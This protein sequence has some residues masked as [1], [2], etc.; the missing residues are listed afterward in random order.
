VTLKFV[1][2]KSWCGQLILIMWT[3]Y[4]P[5]CANGAAFAVPDARLLELEL[6]IA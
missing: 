5:D 1:L 2:T 4:E 6:P 3:A